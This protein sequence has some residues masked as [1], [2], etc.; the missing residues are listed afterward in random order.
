[1]SD[2]P[3]DM[4]GDTLSV[5]NETNPLDFRDLK[6]KSIPVWLPDGQEYVLCE[7]TADAVLAYRTTIMSATKLGPNG[8]P[9]AV[10]GKMVGAEPTVISQCLFK[11]DKGQKSKQCVNVNLIKAQPSGIMDALF[12]SLREMSPGLQKDS[13]ES[14]EKQIEGLQ[15]RLDKLKSEDGLV[16]N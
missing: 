13:I 15:K 8:K 14:L 12:T 7:A 4:N 11:I 1:M 2:E 9:S 5:V 6:P 10:D 3:M 16:K